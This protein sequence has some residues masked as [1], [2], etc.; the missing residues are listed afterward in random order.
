MQ[1]ITKQEIIN[2]FTANGLKIKS[3]NRTYIDGII[4]EL[5]VIDK[6]GMEGTF[7]KDGSYIGVYG[8]PCIEQYFLQDKYTL[9]NFFDFF[10]SED[11]K[12]YFTLADN[13]YSKDN[14]QENRESYRQWDNQ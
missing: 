2:R 5:E 8:E 7:Y 1:T 6:N 10:T 13:F 3:D 9:F 4:Y 12:K 11:V 14:E